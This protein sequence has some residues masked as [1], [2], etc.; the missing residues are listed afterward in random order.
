MQTIKLMLF[1]AWAITVK[2]STGQIPGCTDY[3]ASNYKSSATINDGSCTYSPT[4]YT[5]VK[6]ISKLSDTLDGTSALICINGELW[7]LNDDGYSNAIYHLDKKDGHILQ[8]IYI[9]KVS[10][11]DWESMTIDAQYKYIYIGNTGNNF[12]NRKNLEIYRITQSQ[13]GKKPVDTVDA[14]VISYSYADQS[15]FTSS[16]NNT[17]FDCDAMVVINDTIHLFSKDWIG[18]NTKHYIMPSSPGTYVLNPIDSF[19]V[20]CMISDAAYDP[21]TRRITLTGYE[22]SGA[23]YLWLLWDYNGSKVFSGNKRRIDIGFFF[24]TGQVDGAC[25]IDSNTL[26]LTNENNAVVNSLM[27]VNSAQWM[28]PKGMGVSKSETYDG[29]FTLLENPAH[30]ILRLTCS[31]NLDGPL[32]LS[33][34]DTEGKRVSGKV[35]KDGKLPFPIDIEMLDYGTYILVLHDSAGKTWQKIFIKE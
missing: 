15:D 21:F 33:I 31:G 27:M 6:V 29:G 32:Y 34:Y 35:L 30:N 13:I 16:L 25:F 22:S 18:G 19:H 1:L 3:R 8:S 4:A 20:G 7:S 12:G 14:D 9:R 10:K 23:C 28:G 26:Y 17:R 11:Y 5:P 2:I 24:N